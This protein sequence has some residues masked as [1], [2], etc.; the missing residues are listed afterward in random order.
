MSRCL[1]RCRNLIP[2][3][4][5]MPL[6]R[7]TKFVHFG[8]QARHLSRQ[9]RCLN[10][11]R[12]RRQRYHW[13]QFCRESRSRGREDRHWSGPLCLFSQVFNADL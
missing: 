12:L 10:C 11:I 2:S 1:R 9:N 4:L 13:C 5:I 3:S 7:S 8:L 6:N